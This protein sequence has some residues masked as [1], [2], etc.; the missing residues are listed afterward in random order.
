MALR[1]F[2]QVL[3]VSTTASLEEINTA[4]RKLAKRFH[5]D[6]N[7]GNKHIEERFKEITEAYNTLSDEEKRSKYDL[8]FLYTSNARSER[9][10]YSA[11]TKTT[12][13]PRYKVKKERPPT[14]SEKRSVR[15]IFASVVGFIIL[16]TVM[17]ILNPEDEE[18]S[19][20]NR[21]MDEMKKEEP[22]MHAP[23]EKPLA[24]HDAD[25]PY[26]SIFGEGVSV[27]EARSTITVINSE[28]SEVI[29]CLVQKDPPHHTIRN[30][31]FGP[32]LSYKM[33]GIPNG[34]YYLKV[35]FGKHWNPGKLLA[36][37]KVKGGFDQEIGFFRSDRPKDIFAVSQH[38]TGDNLVYSNYE[39]ELKKIMDDRSKKISAEEFFK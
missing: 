22:V 20:V 31:Y 8:K 38:N 24:I 11:A 27:D 15:I 19:S 23:D 30:E 26:D 3:G 13:Q 6:R 18:T 21:M 17:I 35:Y 2:Y 16:V 28:A 1:N 4:Y 9:T 33:V 5:P 12:A 14:K 10:T 36:G 39:V 37:G 32:G 25:S 7:P 29:A 34:N